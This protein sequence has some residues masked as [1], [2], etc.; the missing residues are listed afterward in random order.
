MV[1]E[2]LLNRLVAHRGWP[3][4]YPENSLSGMRAVLEAGAR[5]VEFDVQLS[6]D[7]QSLVFHDDQLDR[8]LG[9]PGR[10]G[11]LDLQELMASSLRQADGEAFSQEG[12]PALSDMLALMADWPDVGI[13]LEI[14]RASLRRFGRQRMVN[15]VLPCL[16]TVPN[17]LVIISFDS[18]VLELIRAH[19]AWP[20]GWVFKPWDE[21]ARREA[22]RLA[23]EYLFVRQDRVPDSTGGGNPFWAGPWQWVL[24]DVDKAPQAKQWLQRGAHLIETD[25]LPELAG[26]HHAGP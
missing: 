1:D 15:A 5:F 18:P 7:L 11:D 17:P 16:Q 20:I 8:M 25:Y 3:A 14:K 9:L 12:P 10:V 24:Y 19:S 2:G 6:A 26:I 22:S 21:Q 23:P 4:R 13:F